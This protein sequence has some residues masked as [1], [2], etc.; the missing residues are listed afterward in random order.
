MFYQTYLTQSMQYKGIYYKLNCL[1][2]HTAK[3]LKLVPQGAY[4]HGNWLVP[5]LLLNG[6]T[7]K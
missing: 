1:A 4:M 2:D 7:G 3:K 6:Q 5:N